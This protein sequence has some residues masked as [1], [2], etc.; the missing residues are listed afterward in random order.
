VTARSVAKSIPPTTKS[1][2]ESSDVCRIALSASYL[3]PLGELGRRLDRAVLHH[4]ARSTV[5]SFLSR[6]ATSVRSEETGASYLGA[7]ATTTFK[8]G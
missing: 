8:V 2:R 4:V 3:T 1:Q 6:L 5:R 7:T